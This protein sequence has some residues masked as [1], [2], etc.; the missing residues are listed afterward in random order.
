[1]YHIYNFQLI[2]QY[3]KFL[4][5][6]NSLYFYSLQSLYF[7]RNILNDAKSALFSLLT[8]S[9]ELDMLIIV[10]FPFEYKNDSPFLFLLL[11]FAPFTKA[12]KFENQDIEEITLYDHER[13]VQYTCPFSS[14]LVYYN[15]SFS[16]SVIFNNNILNNVKTSLL[17]NISSVCVSTMEL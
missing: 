1:M 12:I 16:F 2:S 5:Y 9:S 10:S 11:D 15:D 6:N 8:F 7:D 17:A 13:N 3:Y 14:N 4:I